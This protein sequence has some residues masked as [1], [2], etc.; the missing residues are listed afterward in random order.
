MRSLALLVGMVAAHISTGCYA[1]SLRD[2]TVTCSGPDPC[3]GNQVCLQGL[4][5][6]P[7]VT[8]CTDD[9]QPVIVDAS[10]MPDASADA[11]PDAYDLCTQGCS[12]GTCIGGICTIDCS[13]DGACPDD[14]ACPANLPCHVICGDGACGHKV[15][16][17]MASSC[18][19]DCSGEGACAD[20]IQCPN[21]RECDVNCTG[22]SSCKRRTK[23]GM[24]CACDVTCSGSGSCGEAS[25]CPASECRI[26]NGCSSL[27][28]PTCDDC[29]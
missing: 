1:P 5:A 14:V 22:T 28:D 15:N 19:V 9:G 7:N 3:A 12:M 18:R 20:E 16:C 26:G 29:P 17:T 24:S 4:C 11:R 27:V 23:C 25:E 2:C 6:A 21:H 13:A 10:P 8:R